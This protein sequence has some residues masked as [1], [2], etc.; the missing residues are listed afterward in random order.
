VTSRFT[1]ALLCLLVTAPLAFAQPSDATDL[2]TRIGNL[3]SLDYAVRTNAARQVRRAAAA[4]AVPALVEAARSHSDE[5]VRYRAFI[6]LTS[7]SERAT[8]DL[9]RELLRDRNDRVRQV[10]YQWLEQHPDP[11]LADTLL[12]L[13]QTE[14]AEFV[15]P[16][17]IGAVA[18][19]GNN[20]A[21][22]RALIA[23][24]GRGLDFFRSAVIDSLGHHRAT[25]AVDAIASVAQLEGPLQ[26]DAVL[27]LGRIGD[28][29]ATAVLAAISSPS[30]D[31]ALTLRA[32]RCLLGEDCDAQVNALSEAAL[33]PRATQGAVRSAIA[34]LA[35]IAATG[36]EGATGALVALAARGG[37][38]RE[39]A[40]VAFAT[41]AIRRPDHMLAWLAMTPPDVRP[42]AVALVKDGFESLEEDFGEEQFFAATRAAYWKVPETAP[43]RPLM[44]SLIESLEF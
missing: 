23:E 12:A 7:F 28:K 21:V 39:E 35:A 22:Q 11:R 4:D 14:Q 24:T 31:V 17:L 43:I 30:A 33:A 44:A 32:A 25:Y 41:V 9:A 34:G 36:H 16:A 19:L 29:R 42:N 13:L 10:A 27:A 15:R 3:G 8:G 1:L 20:A 26:D 38:V 37:A 40:A 6:L 2:K 5:F 18:A